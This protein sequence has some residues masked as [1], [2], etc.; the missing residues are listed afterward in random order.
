MKIQQ[1]R[2]ATMGSLFALALGRTP[3]SK[4]RDIWKYPKTIHV[5]GVGRVPVPRELAART[6]IE[7]ADEYDHKKGFINK[8]MKLLSDNKKYHKEARDNSV[9][10][11]H[12]VEIRGVLVP[13]VRS[14]QS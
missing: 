10:G 11:H 1:F 2:P 14:V 4:N 6:H 12:L 7:L 13:T 9:K 3:L 5:A 8:R